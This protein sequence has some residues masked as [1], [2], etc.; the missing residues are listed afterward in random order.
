[1]LK[2]ASLGIGIPFLMLAVG[3]VIGASLAGLLIDAFNFMYTFIIYG[4]IGFI[5]LFIY[6]KVKLEEKPITKRRLQ[7]T[8]TPKTPK[9]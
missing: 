4:V 7:P 2:N 9:L 6:P 8:P 1:L 5:P 3:Q